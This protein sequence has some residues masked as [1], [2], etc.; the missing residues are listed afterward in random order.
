MRNVDPGSLLQTA[1]QSPQIELGLR[2]ETASYDPPMS[3]ELGIWRLQGAT[4]TPVTTSALANEATLEAILE[5]DPSIL[6]L[7]VLLV[8]G[9]QVITS[10]GT[11]IDL[12]C[13]D[14]EGTLFVI[15][16]K[17]A[18]TPREV[19]AQA[20]DYG[21]WTDQVSTDEI[22]DLY[23]RH[24]E[25]ESF[26]D[27]FRQ[28]FDDD[29]PEELSGDHQ[30][31]I[32]A[33]SLDPSTD[34]IVQ[35]VRERGVPIYVVFFQYFR[36]GEHEF[37]ART[38]DADPLREGAA[39][40]VTQKKTRAAWNGQDFY[41]T[42][43][44]GERRAWEDAL[45]YG[46]VSGG[47]GKWYSQTLQALFPGARVFVHIPQT[48]Y[49][50]VGKV[51]ETAQR[52][53]DFEVEVDG[54]RLPILEA[55]LR[56]PKMGERADDE[57]QSEYLVRVEWQKTLPQEKAIWEKGMFANQNTVVRLRDPF[58]LER[59]VQAFDLDE[60]EDAYISML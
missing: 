19:V 48:G 51:M 3:V 39:R 13:I 47:G 16:V 38:W 60:H 31:V 7:D 12:L 52:V 6:G 58:T 40:P 43:G 37:L 15:E 8:I 41:V 2:E 22:A 10:F 29:A 20:L 24:H 36:D 56:A 35:Y 25:G 18:R 26:A 33:S 21:F 46:F 28:R 4:T 45:R 17:K 34:R 23:A 42:F 11:R 32:V 5:A 44:E 55:P 27:G 1:E 30:L 59:L 53:N 57:E 50:A 14:G 49:I 54:R 9:R